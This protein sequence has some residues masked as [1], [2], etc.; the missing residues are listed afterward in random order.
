MV[1]MIAMKKM[2]STKKIIFPS[3][4]SLFALFAFFIAVLLSTIAIF[5]T[6]VFA[7]ITIGTPTMNKGI[8]AEGEEIVISVGVASPKD[9][10]S[11]VFEL[12]N[13]TLNVANSS[14]KN[15]TASLVGSAMNG[16]WLLF[17]RGGVGSAG[18]YQITKVI[19]TDNSSA[20]QARFFESNLISFKVVSLTPT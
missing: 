17:F 2:L 16:N 6:Q 14:Y 13:F 11:V 10:T 20:I 12:K 15:Y 18:I 4:F 3:F 1:V 7:D 8:A 9:V 19:A 5:P